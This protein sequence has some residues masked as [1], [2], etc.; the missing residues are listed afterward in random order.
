MSEAASPVLIGNYCIVNGLQSATGKRS[1]GRKVFVLKTDPDDS[2]RLLAM[3]AGDFG[4]RHATAFSFKPANLTPAYG[5]EPRPSATGLSG[6]GVYATKDYKK[7]DII[8][9][10]MPILVVSNEPKASQVNGAVNALSPHERSILEGLRSEAPEAMSEPIRKANGGGDIS[11]YLRAR[12]NGITSVAKA[13][14]YVYPMIGRMAHM[15]SVRPENNV[16]SCPNDDGQGLRLLT[17]A[18]DIAAGEELC[19][20]YMDTTTFDPARRA[21]LLGPK[22]YCLPPCDCTLCDTSSAET[23][24]L[25]AEYNTHVEALRNFAKITGKAGPMKK[26]EMLQ[27]HSNNATI[28]T[29]GVIEACVAKGERGDMI[30]CNMFTPIT[31]AKMNACVSVMQTMMLGSADP[32]QAKELHKIIEQTLLSRYQAFRQ[33]CGAKDSHPFLQHEK[34]SYDS[35]T[36]RFKMMLSMR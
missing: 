27:S 6:K 8:L 14:T 19:Y 13:S 18:R 34:Q 22:Q 7:G 36:A 30:S 26:L 32:K 16:W 17:A 25:F 2:D 33:Y 3:F 15:C 28:A 24:A 5:V 21:E 20:D 9:D 12:L 1:N 10:E 35:N 4:D 23:K 11:W 31:T 29:R